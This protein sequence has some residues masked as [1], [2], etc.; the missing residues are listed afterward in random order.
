MKCINTIKLGRGIYLKQ[1][2]HTRY[3]DIK[4]GGPL[5]QMQTDDLISAL[6]KRRTLAALLRP[7][8]D[9]A[10]RRVG[11]KRQ[12]HKWWEFQYR[13]VHHC[14]KPICQFSMLCEVGEM[15]KQPLLVW[16]S[17]NGYRFGTIDLPFAPWIGS[18][19]IPLQNA[20]K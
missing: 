11:A 7:P 5:S 8:S 6:Y 14:S 2:S 1:Y 4:T 9:A 20:E 19:L 18:V 13:A 17:D 12:V 3:S 16:A 10:L 15:Y